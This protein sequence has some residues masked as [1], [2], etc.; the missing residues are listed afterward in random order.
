METSGK[1]LDTFHWHDLLF[2]FGDCLD[3]QTSTSNA[4]AGLAAKS[5]LVE[6]L[7]KH[8]EALARETIRKLC[9]GCGQKWYVCFHRKS[10]SAVAKKTGTVFGKTDLCF[11]KIGTAFGKIGWVCGKT[12]SVFGKDRQ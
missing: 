10:G 9:R 6:R 1:E 3:K 5:A 2:V 7:R 11:R 12:G 4:L 8:I